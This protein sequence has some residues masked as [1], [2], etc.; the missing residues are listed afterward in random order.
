MKKLQLLPLYILALN[1]WLKSLRLK[2]RSAKPQ[3]ADF[4]FDREAAELLAA[5][6]KQSPQFS[7][8][9]DAGNDGALIAFVVIGLLLLH[10]ISKTSS[11]RSSP[12]P[13]MV[14]RILSSFLSEKDFECVS[15]DL[16][17]EFGTR[18][19]TVG[20]RR[21]EL[22]VCRQVVTSIWPLALE[23]AKAKVS[24]LLWQRTQ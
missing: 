5:K 3:P 15:G 8:K 18:V 21:A 10:S 7:A 6:F 16:Q 1:C 20:I 23:A 22:W 4:R 17:E 12:L 11:N 2:K 13:P 9:A 14:E 24:S 19:A